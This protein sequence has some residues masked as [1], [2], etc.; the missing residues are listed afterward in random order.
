M[1]GEF[2]VFLTLSETAAMLGISTNTL[3][4]MCECGMIKGAVRF[5]KIWMIPEDRCPEDDFLKRVI[6]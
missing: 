1:E 4:E 2:G 5:G 3:R 6:T